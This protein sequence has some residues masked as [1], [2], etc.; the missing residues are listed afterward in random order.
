MGV[1]RWLQSNNYSMAFGRV[2]VRVWSHNS[3]QM[4]N[5]VYQ[6]NKW[7]KRQHFFITD[8][9]L[10]PTTGTPPKRSSRSQETNRLQNSR[11]FLSKSVKKSVKH[12]V[13]VLRARSVRASQA[14][15]GRVRR[16]KKNLFLASISSLAL[17]FSLV[18]DLLFDCLHVLEY[19]KIR[20]VLQSRKQ[21]TITL[22]SEEENNGKVI[23][24]TN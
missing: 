21:T 18:P 6:M 17:G 13:R 15:I 8:C 19:A 3:S 22:E 23:I 9:F 7:I 2:L 1:S 14:R 4:R 11:F 16:E 20:T 24:I 5:T 12:G 10:G